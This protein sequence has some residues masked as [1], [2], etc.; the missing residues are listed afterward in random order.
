MSRESTTV[1]STTVESAD[2]AE[3]REWLRENGD[4]ADEVWLVIRHARSDVPSVRH[5][6]AVEEALCFGWI[7]GLA[8]GHD[9]TSMR[10]RFTPRN[11]RSAWSRVNRERVERLTAQGLMTPR[12]QAAVDLA[13]RTG[14]WSVLA[15]AQ[16][17]IVPDD[18]R[19][20][21]AADPRAE[22]RFAALSRS[23][24]RAALEWIARAKRPE[25]RERRIA[26]TVASAAEG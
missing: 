1:S 11:P 13:K 6:E 15:E 19:A 8:R 22:A 17:G 26:R 23:A 10:Q 9:A 18:L 7:D 21:L 20:R 24:R 5:G 25:P 4:T 2:R 14:T 3:W 12:G 16:D